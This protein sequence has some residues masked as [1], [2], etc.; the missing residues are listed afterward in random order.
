[1]NRE[2]SS[3]HFYFINSAKAFRKFINPLCI[4]LLQVALMTTGQAQTAATAAGGD[5]AGDDPLESSPHSKTPDASS[6]LNADLIASM[7][8]SRSRSIYV[9]FSIFIDSRG[10]PTSIVFQN[11]KKY[12]FHSDYL[13]TR[14]EFAGLQRSSFDVMTLQNKNRK[15]LLGTVEMPVSS[16]LYN[17][18]GFPSELY[19]DFISQDPLP[20]TLILAAQ[21]LLRSSM[22]SVKLLYSPRGVLRDDAK[23]T[24]AEL[25]SN[26]IEV[27]FNESN[28]A[29]SVYNQGW[30][31]GRIVRIK[32]D[33]LQQALANHTIASDDFLIMDRAPREIP[34]LA[35]LIVDEPTPPSSHVA[36]LTKMYNIPFM[37]VANAMS[38]TEF[39]AVEGKRVY[40]AI[41][42]P[43][44]QVIPETFSDTVFISKNLTTHEAARLQAA[45]DRKTKTQPRLDSQTSAIINVSAMSDDALA[46]YGSKAVKMGLLHRIVP[47]NVPTPA[48]G[49]PIFYFNRFLKEAR[50]SNGNSLES[51][52]KSRVA[53]IEKSNTETPEVMRLSQEIQTAF[54]DARINTQ[55][56]TEIETQLLRTFPKSSRLKLRS[57][58]NAEDLSDFNGAGLYDSYAG[59]LGDVP[60]ALALDKDEKKKT[61]E[62]AIRKVWA[63]LF[64]PRGVLARREFGIKTENVGMGILVQPSIKNELANGVAIVTP[65]SYRHA[66]DMAGFPGEDLQVTNPT[67]G[68]IPE[69][70][71][72]NYPRSSPSP[73]INL[74]TV[75]SEVP[76]GR[77]LLEDNEYTN[78]VNLMLQVQKTWP[79]QNQKLDFEWKII[80]T[81]TQE[82]APLLKQ[83]RAVPREQGVLDEKQILF[84]GQSPEVFYSESHLEIPD[85]IRRFS[86]PYEVRLHWGVFTLGELFSGKPVVEKLIIVDRHGEH[87]FKTPSPKIKHGSW[88][89]SSS[90]DGIESKRIELIF[91]VPIPEVKTLTLTFS[92]FIHRDQVTKRM[93]SK[94]INHI[95]PPVG[96][97]EDL[98]GSLRTCD[99]ANYKVCNDSDDFFRLNWEF[100]KSSVFTNSAFSEGQDEIYHRKVSMISKNKQNQFNSAI[101]ITTEEVGPSEVFTFNPMVKRTVISGITAQPLII[102]KRSGMAYGSSHHNFVE[103]WIFDLY[104]AD[105]LTQ[106]DMASLAKHKVRYLLV[107][108]KE[109]E[110]P[111]IRVID[112]IGKSPRM[113]APIEINAEWLK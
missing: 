10:N 59:W 99:S 80:K 27:R 5:N 51:E 34:P 87:I 100:G 89:P 18:S 30:A 35:G 110:A 1:M 91:S 62:R 63:S 82:R 32:A 111:A 84:V 46:T 19:Y 105:N 50:L 67:D 96:H 41:K 28:Q 12:A 2:L 65:D 40:I 20:T 39:K 29:I 101:S 4:G 86:G 43:E 21:N 49:I 6:T 36:L 11:S 73:I 45:R 13:I 83:V 69:V 95:A 55:F 85:A 112:V 38:R 104:Q 60:S 74:V 33:Q 88:K 66:I 25:D 107:D 37:R 72:I 16:D 58:S 102:T 97:A 57:S 79:D 44:S 78:L 53:T 26:G 56:W 94:V 108:H 68:K 92:L 113:L 54:K 64:N 7:S 90:L 77:K 75:S 42:S 70:V 8:T 98:L 3:L 31:I 9:K 103:Q 109:S 71:S 106:Q 93:T 47:Q 48:V 61:L 17:G 15:I 23:S 24:A 76:T 52:I 22:P 81:A 14:P